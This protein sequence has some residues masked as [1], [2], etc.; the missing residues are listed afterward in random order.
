[1]I[2]E[3]P[4]TPSEGAKNGDCQA[5]LPPTLSG[6][7]AGLQ[8]AQGTR[9]RPSSSG[10]RPRISGVGAG[11]QPALRRP[12]LIR[13]IR[14]IRGSSFLAGSVSDHG[15]HGWAR[16][17]TDEKP[18]PASRAAALDLAIPPQSSP[19]T[20]HMPLILL[21]RQ[22]I[23][24]VSPAHSRVFTSSSFFGSSPTDSR[25]PQGGN[26][27]RLVSERG[28]CGRGPREGHGPHDR[29][30]T[31]RTVPPPV[32]PFE[33]AEAGWSPRGRRRG[34]GRRWWRRGF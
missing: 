12:V 1:M 7:G 23:P 9:R 18:S 20:G 5:L 15:L 21:I 10:A 33:R 2:E 34:G 4:F 14:A 32:S 27:P 26:K 6:V 31:P 19:K 17:R 11:S 16:I 29:G 8:P 3:P 30:R 22:S 28:S 13:V 24:F 25:L